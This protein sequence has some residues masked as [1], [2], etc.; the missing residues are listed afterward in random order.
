VKIIKK[1]N[2]ANLRL[3]PSKLFLAMP[4]VKTLS[5]I[6][7]AAGTFIDPGRITAIN[8]WISPRGGKPFTP[9][10]HM[11]GFL[12]YLRDYISHYATITA[13]LEA[14]KNEPHPERHWTDE[15]EL[16]FQTIK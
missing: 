10:N 5:F 7:N 14:I 6:K 13:P 12:N 2:E 1:L 3:E 11:L 4:Q 15:H 8:S 9:I 16:A